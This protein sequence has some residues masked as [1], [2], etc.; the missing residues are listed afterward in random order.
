M[1]TSLPQFHA[2]PLALQ[3]WCRQFTV[4]F[5]RCMMQYLRRVD[6]IVMN[7][8]LTV[9]LSVFISC[10]IWHQIGTNQSS[11]AVRTP[12]LF[13]ACVTQ[14]IVAS[15]QT[16][17]S[18]PIERAIILRER[19][20]GAYNVSAYF[21]A[22]TCADFLTTSWGPTLFC[23]IVYPTIGYQREWPIAVTD[24]P[25]LPSYPIFE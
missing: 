8:A 5:Q 21:M 12:S 4:L 13:F 14:G 10:G 18:F 24:S 19:A 11:V 15:L 20:A 1:G 23:A 25:D 2:S 16:I 6:L 3:S 9:I 17:S 22:R 7:L